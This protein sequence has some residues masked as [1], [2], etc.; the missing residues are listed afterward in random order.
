ME[1]ENKEMEISQ[2]PKVADLEFKGLHKDF[3]QVS[4][5]S[6]IVQWIII[7]AIIITGL[8]FWG[9]LF[10]LKVFLASLGGWLLFMGISL[11]LRWL[12][13]RHKAYALRERDIHYKTGLLWRSETSIPFHRIQHAEVSQGLIERVFKLSRLKVFTAGGESSDLVVPGLEPDHA[14]SLKDYIL[15]KSALEKVEE[16]E[17][18]LFEESHDPV[19]DEIYNDKLETEGTEEIQ[20]QPDDSIGEEEQN[21]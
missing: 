8:S 12:G 17:V 6:V 18:E 9:L 4:I 5:L 3:L 2:L 15:N 13:F 16:A 21:G 7:L 20:S 11:I 1:F 19:L 14:N 10:N